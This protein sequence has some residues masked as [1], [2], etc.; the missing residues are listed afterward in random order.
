MLPIVL[1]RLVGL[2][3]TLFVASLIVFALLRLSG[4]D[5]AT[6]LLGDNPDP[7][8]LAAL[9][10]SMGLDDPA[11]MQYLHWLS[12][13]LHGDLGFSYYQDKPVSDIL[14]PRIAPTV[15]LAILAQILSAVVAI[16]LGIAAARRRN[17]PVDSAVMG[18]TLLGMAVPSF[19]IALL[20]A[21][22]FGVTLKWFPVLGYKPFSEGLGPWLHTLVLPAVSLAI[23]HAALTIRMTR[24]SLIDSLQ[25]DYVRTARAKG[26]SARRVVYRH[27]LKNAAIP[28]LTVIGLGFGSLVAGALVTETVFN[29]PGLGQ[30]MVTSISHRDLP[31]IQ[32]VVLLITITYA[33]L[34]LAVDLL[35]AV[36]DP[37]ISY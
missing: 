35:Y 5:P 10:N 34:N 17:G 25:Q 13:I 37:R 26:A 15:S 2:V 3:A 12:G 16:P 30:L 14:L 33:L 36:I 32:G 22:F 23:V 6:V 4:G 21:V 29:I 1:K 18:V 19:V 20:F 8:A 24:A 11:P 7:D 9:R 31:V 27:A 28:I